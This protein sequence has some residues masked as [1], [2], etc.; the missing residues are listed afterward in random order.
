[1]TVHQCPNILHF[2]R[3]SSHGQAKLP[4]H[5]CLVFWSLLLFS[6]LILS[7]LDPSLFISYCLIQCVFL[8]SFVLFLSVLLH[9]VSIFVLVTLS[10][11]TL[12]H[13]SFLFLLFFFCIIF[14]VFILSLILPFLFFRSCLSC[15]SHVIWRFLLISSSLVLFFSSCPFLFYFLSHLLVF[16]LLFYFYVSCPLL[17][18]L[19]FNSCHFS[20]SSCLSFLCLILFLFSTCLILFGVSFSYTICL[21]SAPLVSSLPFLFSSHNL[22]P[23]LHFLS[24]IFY[25]HPFLSSSPCFNSCFIL[26]LLFI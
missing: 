5:S 20:F 25:Y 17:A 22:F 23:F 11:L 3:S 26:S 18:S 16:F 13:L 6:F 9:P 8:I 1:M 21:V 12:S 2:N 24:H 14:S 4:L 15:L 7:H 19:F 10:F